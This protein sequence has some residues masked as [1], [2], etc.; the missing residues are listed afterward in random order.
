MEEAALT[1]REELLG[2]GHPDTLVKMN[3]PKKG[4]TRPILEG[5]PSANYPRSF[6]RKVGRSYRRRQSGR[7]YHSQLFTPLKN[8]EEAEE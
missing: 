1:I 7:G 6:I 5:N 4:A 2:K 3:K 8:Y